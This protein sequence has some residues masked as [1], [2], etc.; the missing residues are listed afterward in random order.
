MKTWRRAAL[1]I[2]LLTFATGCS[3]YRSAVIP[4]K[5]DPVGTPVSD[6]PVVTKGMDARIHLK[7]G[8]TITGEVV[9]LTDEFITVGRVGNYGFELTDVVFDSIET[10]EV[11]D[12]SKL[13]SVGMG[14]FGGV[15]IAF[16]G[17]VVLALLFWRFEPSY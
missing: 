10:I 11:E 15:T 9:E 5:L 7:N 13:A 16:A 1:S 12:A 4:G 3:G 8:E 17:V 2:A 14:I 6:R